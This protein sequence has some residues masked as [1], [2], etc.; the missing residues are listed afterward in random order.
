MLFTFSSFANPFTQKEN[1]PVPVQHGKTDERITKGMRFLSEKLASYIEGWKNNHSLKFIA[2]TLLISFAFGFVHALAPGH[3]KIVVFTYFLS[4]KAKVYEPA[5][6]GLLLASLHAFSALVIMI[7]FKRLSGAISVSTNNAT[8]YMEGVTFV[9]LILLSVYGVLEAIISFFNA[10]ESKEKK[11]KITAILLSGLYPCPAAM[12][13]LVFAVN[14]QVFSLGVFA[15]LA[16]SL[17]MSVP[18][19]ISGYL[20]WAGRTAIFQKLI[21]NK[22]KLSLVA[23]SLQ[24]IA[25]SFL[26]IISTKIALPF[27]CGLFR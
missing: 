14:L 26:L 4:K 27:I 12:L 18:I 3:R 10:P 8:L 15:I 2:L 13:V 6:L 21:K 7:I 25:F 16:L 24:L 1:S 5:F 22:Q 23:N 9:V 20:A 11:L 17:G 19:I